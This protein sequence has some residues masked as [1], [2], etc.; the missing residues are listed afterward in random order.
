[1]DMD[2]YLYCIEYS[3]YM[4]LKKVIFEYFKE[5]LQEEIIYKS[6]YI[7]E[8][9]YVED[10]GCSLFYMSIESEF[11]S[12]E[13]DLEFTLEDYQ[14]RT[15]VLICIN[16]FTDTIIDGICVLKG[17]IKRLEDMFQTNIIVLDNS[18]KEVYIS[19]GNK[20]YIDEAFWNPKRR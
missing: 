20:H 16:L 1:M 9:D 8:T 17:L 10:C 6:N 14:I 5:N 3:N 4:M 11:T 19:S 18:S 12:K 15:N 13:L 2:I 7:S